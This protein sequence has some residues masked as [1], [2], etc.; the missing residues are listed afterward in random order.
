MNVPDKPRLYREM[1]R[2]LRPAGTL[3]IYDVLAWPSAPVLFPVPWA[4][5][6]ETSFLVT[7]EELRGL[8]DQKVSQKATSSCSFSRRT[9]KRSGWLRMSAT[10][11]ARSC[12]GASVL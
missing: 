9:I 4:R 3:A 12:T 11:T 5:L 8:L 7:P 6:P 1:Y 2:V 10:P